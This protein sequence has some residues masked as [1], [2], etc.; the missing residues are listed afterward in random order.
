MQRL[1][2]RMHFSCCAADIQQQTPAP[3]QPQQQ[4]LVL[5]QQAKLVRLPVLV[6]SPDNQVGRAGFRFWYWWT[7]ELHLSC[8]FWCCRPTTRYAV[9]YAPELSVARE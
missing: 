6:L 7:A 9:L 3:Q 1:D 5:W 4:E 8:Q 2:I